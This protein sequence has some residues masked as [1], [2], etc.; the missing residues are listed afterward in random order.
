MTSHLLNG[1][2][3]ELTKTAFVRKGLSVVGR[4]LARFTPKGRA[5]AKAKESAARV[6][7]IRAQAAA[8]KASGVLVGKEH[9][10][11]PAMAKERAAL[12]ERAGQRDVEF[13]KATKGLSEKLKKHN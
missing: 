9:L 4:T 1:F 12:F 2:A 7:K 5:A 11:R 3:D 13:R 6:A 8:D 10:R